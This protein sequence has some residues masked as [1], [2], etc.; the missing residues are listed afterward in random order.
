LLSEI[1]CSIRQKW[2]A[3]TPEEEV[4]QQLI[5]KMVERQGYPKESISVE[6]ALSNMPHLA[7]LPF[8]R[9]PKRRADIVVWSS[10][11]HPLFPLYPLLLIECKAGSLTKKAERQALGYNYYLGA[12]FVGLANANE[13]KVADYKGDS[14]DFHHQFPPFLSL[15]T[16][17]SGPF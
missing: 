3:A 1:Y 15:M 14:E 12:Y 13:M 9:F 11:I 5:L 8:S 6:T 17:V 7:H 10:K 16:R 4:R 2:V